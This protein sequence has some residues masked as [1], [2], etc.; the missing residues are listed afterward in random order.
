MKRVAIPVVNGRLSEY[1]GKCS[2][3]KIF[4]IDVK[5]INEKE[6]E[7]P[8]FTDIS[9]LPQWAHKKGITDIISYKLEKN[10]ISMFSMHKINV[11]VGI[12]INTPDALIK[13]YLN[14]TLKSDERIISEIME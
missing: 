2:H 13:E 6:F 5:T 7:V 1:F 11:Y 14:G 8:I 4:D 3:Y 9:V 10:I 12:T